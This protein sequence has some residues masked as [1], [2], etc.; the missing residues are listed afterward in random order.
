MFENVLGNLIADVIWTILL[1][2]MAVLFTQ[3][4]YRRRRRDIFSFFGLNRECPSVTIYVSTMYIHE[5]GTT[6]LEEITQGYVGPAL[7]KIEY[8]TAL[9]LEQKLTERPVAIV[10]EK[11]QTWIGGNFFHIGYA[12]VQIEFSPWKGGWPAV[13][14][15]IGHTLPAGTIIVLGSNIYNSVARWYLERLHD[16]SKCHQY[17][18]FSVGESEEENGT[19]RRERSI[20]RYDKE[21][22]T[23]QSL[24]SQPEPALITR[25]RDEERTVFICAGIRGWATAASGIYLL[26]NWRDLHTRFSGDD[27]AV[28][29]ICPKPDGDLEDIDVKDIRVAVNRTDF[30]L[31]PKSW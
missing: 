21:H 8:Q 18:R 24:P 4:A 14:D 26:R 23:R 11:I 27:F 7:S 20:V 22:K 28:E 1:L 9:L 25:L 30:R 13:R 31:T 17:L 15:S 29:L 3:W 2:F 16:S 10:P 12:N 5:R 6:A 19:K